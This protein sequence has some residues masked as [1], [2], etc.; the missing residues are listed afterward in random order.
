MVPEDP[1]G[2]EVGSLEHQEAKSH[3]SEDLL[4]CLTFGPGLLSLDVK[5]LGKETNK[6]GTRRGRVSSSVR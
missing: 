5:T 2:Y 1:F 6:G 3:L 4:R